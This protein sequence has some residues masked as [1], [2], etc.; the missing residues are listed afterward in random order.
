[1]SPRL[2]EINI[3]LTQAKAHAE[4]LEQELP[5]YADVVQKF[6]KELTRLHKELVAGL[7]G[8]S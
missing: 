4:L 2:Y 8:T 5:Q 7:T 1:M 6:L 3:G